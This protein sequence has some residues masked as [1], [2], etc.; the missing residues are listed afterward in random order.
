MLKVGDWPLYYFANDTAPGQTNGQ[1]A[2]DVW[3]LVKSN[4][5]ES[6]A[7]VWHS[8]TA[9]TLQAW[10]NSRI[11]RQPCADHVPSAPQPR[12]R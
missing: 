8:R 10:R 11:I 7:A 2:N 9:S 4:V 1:G 3:W 6:R 12:R 5:A